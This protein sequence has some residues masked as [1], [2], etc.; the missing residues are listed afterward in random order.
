MK[1]TRSAGSESMIKPLIDFKNVD[2]VLD[3]HTILQ[4]ITWQLRQGEHWAILGSNGS[5]KSTLLKLIRAELC[6]APGKGKRI[7]AF[8]NGEQTSAVGIKEKIALVSPELQERYLQ[9]EWKLTGQ[10]VLYSGSFNT[11]YVYRKPNANQKAFALRLVRLLGIRDLVERDVQQLS[12]GELRKLLI[13]R[14]LAGN[15][16]VAVFDEVCD[17]LD[18]RS[19]AHLLE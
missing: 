16:R 7:Y 2:V 6:P 11:D 14:A 15:P 9:Q 1:A 8:D 5:G 12:T 13:A 10:Q 4:D 17:G 3:G 18:A 19:R